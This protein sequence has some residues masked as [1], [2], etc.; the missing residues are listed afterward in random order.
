[1]RQW[2]VITLIA[3]AA[4]IVNVFPDAGANVG[5]AIII[6]VILAGSATLMGLQR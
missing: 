1:L 3:I 4:I 5:I 6:T 2:L